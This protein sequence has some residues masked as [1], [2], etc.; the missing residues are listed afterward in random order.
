MDKLQMAKGAHTLIQVCAKVKAGEKLL[1]VTEQSMLSIAQS[2]IE[3]AYQAGAEP[4]LMLMPPRLVNGQ[5]PPDTVSAAMKESDVF[6]CVVNR[7]ITHTHAVKQAV[8]AGS[9]G[10]VLTQF[11]ESMMSE[12]GITVDFEAAAPLCRAMAKALAG[13]ESLHLSTPLGTDLRFSAR[14]RRGNALCGLVEAGHFSTV[15]TIEANVSPLEGT[16]QGRIVADASIPYL[17]I[18]LLHEPVSCLVKDGMITAIE[19]GA[20]AE[21][22]RKDLASHEDPLVYNIAELGV[23]LNPACRFTGFMLEDEGVFGSVHIGIGSSLTLGGN[24]KA[25]CHYDLIMTGATLMADG[26]VLI[27]D[28]MPQLR[29]GDAL[30]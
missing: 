12:G 25:K 6:Y 22:L 10:L 8:A 9:R 16:A 1:V 5:E 15:P 23:G 28:G 11:T 3:A 2:L 26:R 30:S 4:V 18:G 29:I 13:A 7:S 19:G 17:G 14:G 27:K 20:Q 21:T 24:V